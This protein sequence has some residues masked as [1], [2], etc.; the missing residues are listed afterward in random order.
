VNQ[1]RLVL[2]LAGFVAA[3]LSIALED[4]RLA[5]G[6]IALLIA[7]LILRLLLRKR[8]GSGRNAGTDL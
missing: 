2:A 4:R 8:Q 6:A 5:W 3:V 7:S 1:A